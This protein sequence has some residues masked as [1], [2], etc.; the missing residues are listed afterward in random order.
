MKFDFL[1]L[2]FFMQIIELMHDSLGIGGGD[3]GERKL[4]GFVG[5]FEDG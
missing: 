2:P 3:F 4:R 1:V 5:N